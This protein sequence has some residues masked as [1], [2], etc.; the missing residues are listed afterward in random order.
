[1]LALTLNLNLTR[2]PFL[3]SFKSRYP[4]DDVLLTFAQHEV[5]CFAD[6]ASDVK[7]ARGLQTTIQKTWG[8]MHRIGE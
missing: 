7:H 8:S 4:V 6:L 3:C 2:V 5:P 1:M